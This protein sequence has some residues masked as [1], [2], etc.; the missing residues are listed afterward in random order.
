MAKALAKRGVVKS[1][2]VL[3]ATDEDLEK[4]AK[5]IGCPKD[6]VLVQLGGL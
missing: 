1:S 2:E 4:M 5:G 3:E 6:L